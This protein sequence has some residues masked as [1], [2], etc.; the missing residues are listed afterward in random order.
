[1]YFLSL[2]LITF[3]RTLYKPNKTESFAVGSADSLQKQSPQNTTNM[4]HKA[5]VKTIQHIRKRRANAPK[6]VNEAGK[7]RRSH[8]EVRLQE[9]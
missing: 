4:Q 3:T 9:A 5:S 7:H 1:M 6:R 8:R 2:F